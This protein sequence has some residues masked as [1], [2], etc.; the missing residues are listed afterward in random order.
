VTTG[1]VGVSLTA[2][3]LVLVTALLIG[4]MVGRWSAGAV[5]QIAHSRYA[6]VA[7]G[8]DI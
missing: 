5:V 4:W 1:R 7:D 3:V 8:S 2:L 6:F